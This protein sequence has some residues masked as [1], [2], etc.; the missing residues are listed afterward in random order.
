MAE[1]RVV[2]NSA[3]V[4]IGGSTGSI[5]V[6]L[7]LLPALRSPLPF[8]LVIVLHRKSTSDT[9][10]ADLFALKTSLPLHDVEDKDVILPGHI[11]LAPADYHLLIEHDGTFSLDDSEKINYSR[12]SIDVTFESAADVYGPALTGILL[13]GANAD[14]TAGLKAIQQAGG[15]T[16]VQ[17]PDTAQVA[18]MPQQAIL[19]TRPDY[20]LDVVGMVRLLER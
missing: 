16:I 7:N 4:V 5:D 19:N 14:G 2:S 12:P 15:L 17:R 9:S 6:L 8:A 18:Y 10:L 20:V 3:M 11:Y 13:S 1:N